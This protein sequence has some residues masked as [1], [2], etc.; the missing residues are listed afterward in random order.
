[1]V[2]GTSNAKV[3]VIGPAEFKCPVNVGEDFGI[4]IDL[5]GLTI[6]SPGNVVPV[7]IFS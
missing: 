7:F 4:Q 1:M 3:Y 5:C 2:F 6:V